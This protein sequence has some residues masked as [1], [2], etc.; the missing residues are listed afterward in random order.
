MDEISV[1]PRTRPNASAWLTRHLARP[2]GASDLIGQEADPDH[3]VVRH[4]ALLAEAPINIVRLGI[5]VNGHLRH[6]LPVADLRHQ[7]GQHRR[8]RP[9]RQQ[10]VDDKVFGGWLRADTPSPWTILSQ[11]M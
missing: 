5:G 4:T 11:W 6:E 2:S 8:S 1:F 9:C 7:A 3:E 10:Q